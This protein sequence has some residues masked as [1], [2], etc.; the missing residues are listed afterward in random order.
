MTH[1]MKPSD[2]AMPAA[3][4]IAPEDT[5]FLMGST[6]TDDPEVAEIWRKAGTKVEAL[7]PASPAPDPVRTALADEMS[8]IITSAM[9]WHPSENGE[10][11]G[12]AKDRLTARLDAALRAA[13]QPS[14]PPLR[15]KDAYEVARHIIG[16]LEGNCGLSFLDVKD[17]DWKVVTNLVASLSLPAGVGAR[18]KITGI[19][20]AK[21]VA[22][23]IELRSKEMDAG[24]AANIIHILHE[25]G[26]AFMRPKV[27][28]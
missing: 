7:F 14:A 9:G 22:D 1:P 6:V 25:G 11:Y 26:V 15:S 2:E 20:A 12:K 23:Y 27:Q 19:E 5:L 16:H 24:D 28:P 18:S 3:W 17:D 13:P 4:R 8:A 10:S 21:L